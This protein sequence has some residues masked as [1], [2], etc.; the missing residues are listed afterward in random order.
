MCARAYVPMI[1]S[2]LGP[3]CDTFLVRQVK[4][5][6]EAGCVVLR[7]LLCLITSFPLTDDVPDSIV[8]SKVDWRRKALLASVERHMLPLLC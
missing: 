3:L 5:C 2:A 4:R 1:S 6:L 7:Q 8:D